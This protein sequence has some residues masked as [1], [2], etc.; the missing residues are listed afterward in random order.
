[1]S[2]GGSLAFQIKETKSSGEVTERPIIDSMT[3]NPALFNVKNPLN[4]SEIE[5]FTEKDAEKKAADAWGYF[6]SIPSE[7]RRR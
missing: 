6:D 7:S 2:R 4:E 1:M 3:A 5:I